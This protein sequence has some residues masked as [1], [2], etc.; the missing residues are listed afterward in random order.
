MKIKTGFGKIVKALQNLNGCF[1]SSA[2]EHSKVE[3]ECVAESMWKELNLKVEEELKNLS[4][5][6]NEKVILKV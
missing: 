6:F 2:C 1:N 5:D 4:I 3:V